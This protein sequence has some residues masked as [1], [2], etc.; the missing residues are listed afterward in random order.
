M[1]ADCILSKIAKKQIKAHIFY[2][3]DEFISFLDI[4]PITEGHSLLIPKKEAETIHDLDEK[5]QKALGTAIYNVSEILKKKYGINI[6]IL[7]TSGK[8]ASQ[9][10]P[11]FHIHLVPRK[12]E[13]RLWDGKKSK[14]IYDRSS[15]FKRLSP[16]KQILEKLCK[17]LKK[18][19]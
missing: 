6:S 11:Y 1:M 14:V 5:Q 4:N 3:D 19:R 16:S 17:E 15:G 8:E 9:S 18:L 2:E 7:N 12:K 13:D 10:V